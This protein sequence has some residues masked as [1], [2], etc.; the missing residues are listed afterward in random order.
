MD[1]DISM[2]SFCL[3]ATKMINQIYCERGID[4]NIL[5]D[6]PVQ[7]MAASVIIYSD[8]RKE[9]WMVGDCHCIVDGVYYDNPKP[10]ESSIAAKR[11]EIIKKALAE[12]ISETELRNNDIGRKA[13]LPLLRKACKEQNVSYPVIDGF[14][15]PIEYVKV[16]K[17]RQEGSEIILA[18]DGYPHLMTTLRES[19][20]ELNRLLRDDPL[21]I[22]ENIATKGL[23]IGQT[24]FD[25]RSY[26]RLTN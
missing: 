9:I 20:A 18:S 25:D 11:A 10:Y 6:D 8:R 12:G 15:I 24:S 1:K 14:P 3:Q 17:T 26:I 2:E 22:K 23:M 19:E 4:I 13:I 16:V 5:K 7:R 21:C